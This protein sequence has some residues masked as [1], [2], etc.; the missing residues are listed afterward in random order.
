LIRGGE[1]EIVG[2]AFRRVADLAHDGLD[3]VEG[4][5]MQAGVGLGGDEVEVQLRV[6]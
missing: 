3:F 6:A 4:L 1:A 2:I 5:L